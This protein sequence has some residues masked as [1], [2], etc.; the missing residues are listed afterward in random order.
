MFVV[1]APPSVYITWKIISAFLDPVT[2]EK[3]K[4]SKTGTEKSLFDF[5]DPSQI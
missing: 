1:N 4:L 2:V 5:A 3:I